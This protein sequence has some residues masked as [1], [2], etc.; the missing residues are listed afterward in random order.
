[1][2]QAAATI[3]H[4]W[5]QEREREFCSVQTLSFE[6]PV[7][8]ANFPKTRALAKEQHRKETIEMITVMQSLHGE[9][10]IKSKRLEELKLLAYGN[11]VD[12]SEAEYSNYHA[13]KAPVR[14]FQRHK[15]HHIR[16]LTEDD[17]LNNEQY[18]NSYSIKKLPPLKTHRPTP[19]TVT[20]KSN[21]SKRF[22]FDDTYGLK[23]KSIK[24]A[25]TARNIGE[26]T[27]NDSSIQLAS[28]SIKIDDIQSELEKEFTLALKNKFS[29]LMHKKELGE[30]PEPEMKKKNHSKKPSRNVAKSQKFDDSKVFLNRP[31]ALRDYDC[32]AGGLIGK[33]ITSPR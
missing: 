10:I 18:T 31:E 26:K 17:E 29:E 32:L 13:K 24:E 9:P 3:L 6:S 21:L 1:M 16:A 23:V 2:L 4:Q 27:A 15:S 14:I 12:V 22:E 33:V 30:L 25:A 11:V 28:V 5:R 20:N 7:Q 19:S 8:K